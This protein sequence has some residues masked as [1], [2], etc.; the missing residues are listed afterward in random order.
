MEGPVGFEACVT[1]LAMTKVLPDVA[2]NFGNGQ[3]VFLTHGDTL[4]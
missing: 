4:K 3:E 1:I 2:K